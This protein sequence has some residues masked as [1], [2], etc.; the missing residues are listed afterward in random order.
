M[1]KLDNWDKMG[2][3]AANR[4]KTS[5]T[6]LMTTLIIN[7]LISSASATR[8]N[9]SALIACLMDIDRPACLRR[10]VR[11][12]LHYSSSNFLGSDCFAVLSIVEGLFGWGP[13]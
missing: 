8:E 4:D 1:D 11:K 3:Q 12:L 5:K 10:I 13:T 9:W 6:G 2:N 7:N